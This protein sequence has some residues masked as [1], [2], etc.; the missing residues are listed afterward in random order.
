MD[1]STPLSGHYA[2]A[3]MGYEQKILLKSKQKFHTEEDIQF[4]KNNGKKFT[5]QKIRKSFCNS[6]CNLLCSKKCC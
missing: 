6:F 4:Y 1:Y 2:G 3:F 5:I